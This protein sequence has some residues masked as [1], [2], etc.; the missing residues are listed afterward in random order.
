LV[1]A[2]IE[3]PTIR[4][5]LVELGMIRDITVDG[6]TVAVLVVF[7]FAEMTIKE[8]ILDAI[9]TAIQKYG[10]VASVHTATMNRMELKEYFSREL[11][12]PKGNI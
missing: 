12:N 10:G 5:N 7:P 2:G 8:R 6:R 9:Q 3:H 4:H 11:F 1:L